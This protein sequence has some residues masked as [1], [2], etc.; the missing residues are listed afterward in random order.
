MPP[1]PE[2]L[3]AF[4]RYQLEMADHLRNPRI[5]SRPPGTSAR[6][7]RVYEQLIHHNLES[8]LLACF[9]VLRQTLGKKRWTSLIRQFISEHRCQTPIFREI[10]AE[11]VTYLSEI[12]VR[13]PDD[14]LWLLALAHYEWLELA[15]SVSTATAETLQINPDGNLA[16]ERPA[17]NPV[18]QLCVYPFPVHRIGPRNKPDTRPERDT[19]L[20]LFRNKNNEMKFIELDMLGATL[21]Q[22]LL[23]EPINCQ[24]ALRSLAAQMPQHV[25]ADFTDAAHTMLRHLYN[26]GAILGTLSEPEPTQQAFMAA[27]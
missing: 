4:Q 15:L 21:I 26:E 12:R 19:T 13:Q 7:M 14:P 11:F 5:V 2:A 16:T 8:F 24:T 10:P 18:L 25:S 20:L 6:R 3:P 9:P 1:Q 22:L 17:F 23:S 27:E